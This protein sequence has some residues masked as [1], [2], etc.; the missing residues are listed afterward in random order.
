MNPDNN[1]FTPGKPVDPDSF[2]GREKQVKELLTMVR[3]AKTRGLQVGWISGERG[4]GKSSLASFVGYLAERDEKAVVAHVHL[5]GVKELDE[6][7]RTTHLQLLKDN[8]T[9][10]WGDALWEKFGKNIKSVDAFGVKFELEKTAD[11]L[12]TRA[13]DFPDALNHVVK[14]AGEDREALLLTFDDIN[15]LAD[16]PKFAHWLKSMVDGQVTSGKRNRV[17]LI[18]A[19]LDE[20]LRTMQK[21]NPSVIR[22]FQPLINID[23]W[24]EEERGNFFR[25]SFAKGNAAI[26]KN[27]ISELVLYS[28]G[29]P[30][31]AHQIGH[32]VWEIAGAKKITHEDVQAGVMVAANNFGGRFLESGVLQALKSEKYRS[33][34]RKIALRPGWHEIEFSKEQLRALTVLT[35]D[36]MK[37]LDNFLNR[38]RRLGAIVPVKEGDRGVYRFATHMHRIY[39]FLEA[40]EAT[41]EGG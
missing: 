36:E 12:P 22:V 6:L 4:I 27:E 39:F 13:G 38:M 32:A 26:G 24:T 19:G 16:N 35:A 41:K 20:R 33:I 2:T 5:G 28:G 9:R 3:M 15:G 1:P 17:C 18:F 31:V 14:T 29:L 25:N 7:A 30:I 34:L 40:W 10:K 23:P 8:Q 11:T 21:A 37:N